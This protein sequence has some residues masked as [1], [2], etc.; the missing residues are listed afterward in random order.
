[1]LLTN[2]GSST[3]LNLFGPEDA[4][5]TDILAHAQIKSILIEAVL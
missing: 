5:I 1:M 3:A 4:A 2:L